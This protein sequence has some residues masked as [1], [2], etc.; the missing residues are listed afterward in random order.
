MEVFCDQMIKPPARVA[1]VR[2]KEWVV[3]IPEGLLTSLERGID[4]VGEEVTAVS[5]T[6]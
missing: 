1:R 4:S 2:S 5:I 6:K 3:R